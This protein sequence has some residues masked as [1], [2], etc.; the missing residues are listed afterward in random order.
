MGAEQYSNLK[1]ELKV[2]LG[3]KVA[4]L[5][6]D[7]VLN[8]VAYDRRRTAQEGNIDVSRLPLLKRLVEEGEA[9]IVLSSSWRRHWERERDGCD[10]I[11][12]EITDIFAAHG[13]SIY[14]K[15]PVL[16]SRDRA[17]EIRAW[18][19]ENGQVE[20]FVIF[21]DIAFGWGEDLQEHLIKTNPRIGFGLEEKHIQAALELLNGKK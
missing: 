12:M 21:D 17:E 14:D 19:A 13:L 9:R 8:S 10:S 18:L 20:A 3:H 6:I 5:D 11:G 4:F 15:T 16:P 2:M 7:G 1:K